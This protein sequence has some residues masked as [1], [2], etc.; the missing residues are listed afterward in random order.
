MDG[1][2]RRR[3]AR[4]GITNV[5]AHLQITEWDRRWKDL[6]CDMGDRYVAV[7]SLVSH[8]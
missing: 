7:F 6:R 4:L 1:E 8:V 5:G 3:G 2:N